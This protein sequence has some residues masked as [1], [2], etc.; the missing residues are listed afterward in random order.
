MRKIITSCAVIKPVTLEVSQIPLF[1][2]VHGTNKICVLV[3]YG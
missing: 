2:L 1:H 3:I